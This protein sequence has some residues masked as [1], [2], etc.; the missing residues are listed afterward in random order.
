MKV[1]ECRLSADDL[2]ITC[3]DVPAQVCED[4]PCSKCPFYDDISIS[5][6]IQMFMELYNAGN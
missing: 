3:D 2:Y 1:M 5:N 4:I 6:L